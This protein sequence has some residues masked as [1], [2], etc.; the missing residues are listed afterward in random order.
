M[1][2][3]CRTDWPEDF[4]AWNIIANAIEASV[5]AENSLANWAE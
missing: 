4:G 2:F 1:H 5:D 3:V